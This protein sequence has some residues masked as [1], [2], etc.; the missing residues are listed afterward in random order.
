MLQKTFI[1]PLPVTALGITLTQH[2][3]TS[4]NILVGTALGQV[5]YEAP[6]CLF[7]CTRYLCV[8]GSLSAAVD[9]TCGLLTR[10]PEGHEKVSRYHL[11]RG[12]TVRQFSSSV[13]VGSRE[14]PQVSVFSSE[15]R[16]DRDAQLLCNSFSLVRLFWTGGTRRLRASTLPAQ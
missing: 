4:K 8:C 14:T 9:F 7:I 12:K 13:V 16:D 3:I 2:G 10:N 1:F 6:C 15:N 5:R 11:R